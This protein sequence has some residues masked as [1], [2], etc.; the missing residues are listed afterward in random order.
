MHVYSNIQNPYPNDWID[1]RNERK[2]AYRIMNSSS[3]TLGQK[4][5]LCCIPPSF[6]NIGRFGFSR[7]VYIIVH[8]DI[9]VSR[10]IM[11]SMHIEKLKTTYNLKR[12]EYKTYCLYTL[13]VVSAMRRKAKWNYSICK[14]SL[15]REESLG[16]NWRLRGDNT[17]LYYSLDVNQRS[18]NNICAMYTYSF[19]S[20]MHCLLEWVAL[21]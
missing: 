13:H 3:S 8:L 5:F 6:Q 12:R 1:E 18:K 9:P 14:V 7:C 2:H 19:G 15:A 16:R 11:I 21:Y 10:C 4:R 17:L 20:R